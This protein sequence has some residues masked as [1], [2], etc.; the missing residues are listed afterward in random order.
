VGAT[1][2]K[3]IQPSPGLFQ[4][5]VCKEAL[6]PEAFIPIA[7]KDKRCKPGHVLETFSYDCRECRT[8]RK[9]DQ[10]RKK[11]EAE[12][13]PF[14]AR[15][16]PSARRAAREEQDRR[17]AAEA[18]ETA[19]VRAAE[20]EARGQE[21]VAERVA[22]AAALVAIAPPPRQKQQKQT[23]P[24]FQPSTLSI[25]SLTERDLERFNAKRDA[26]HPDACWEWNGERTKSGYGAFVF[27]RSGAEMYRVASR[28]AWT[29]ANGPIPDGL[30]VLHRCDNPPCVNPAHLFVGTHDDNMADMVAK[31][32]SAQHGTI[33][34]ENTKKTRCPKCGNAYVLVSLPSQLTRKGKP[35]RRCQQC[36]AALNAAHL[37]VW[38]ARRLVSK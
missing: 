13:R 27:F 31:G 28:V 38:K 4:C 34:A 17:R 7:V 14:I 32:R 20:R 9:R 35:R 1:N 23:R 16:D 10:R 15:S 5:Y 33:A 6:P 8:Q 18:A 37:K 36:K 12:G 30:F 25:P 19:K 21:R 22:K 26:S 24:K 11:A 3:R 2:R 29:I